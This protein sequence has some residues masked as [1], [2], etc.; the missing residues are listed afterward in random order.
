MVRAKVGSKSRTKLV[1]ADPAANALGRPSLASATEAFAGALSPDRA[2]NVSAASKRVAPSAT[3]RSTRSSR[4]ARI[5]VRDR[6]IRGAHR[7]DGGRSS[8][9]ASSPGAPRRPRARLSVLQDRAESPD[10][11]DL[12]RG[13]QGHRPVV[14]AVVVR[15]LTILTRS[16]A[17]TWRRRP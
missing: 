8:S 11:F 5:S 2:T 10:A 13:I 6:L 17:R 7:L 9:T 15:T 14:D 12:D 4:I 1:I 16:S 3:M